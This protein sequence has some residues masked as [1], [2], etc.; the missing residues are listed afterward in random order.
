MHVDEAGTWHAN[1]TVFGAWSAALG[2][3]LD[4][5]MRAPPE[6]HAQRRTIEWGFPWFQLVELELPVSERR[7]VPLA[8]H[9]ASVT[10]TTGSGEIERHLFECA[11][12]V[13][14]QANPL[15]AMFDRDLYARSALDAW[16]RERA[17]DAL[18]VFQ[19]DTGAE[20]SVDFVDEAG[21][22]VH[23]SP[24][25]R[26]GVQELCTLLRVDDHP[27]V[28]TNSHASQGLELLFRAAV[29]RLLR[30][31]EHLSARRSYA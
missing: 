31:R 13:I 29:E 5:L 18:V 25:V 30:C 12:L 21:N 22:R 19:F 7:A 28:E 1:I 2:Y 16:I 17:L 10:G 24:P 14:F 4:W 8:L 15:R 3:T 6:C 23:E 9:V 27:W 20:T 11:D 26:H